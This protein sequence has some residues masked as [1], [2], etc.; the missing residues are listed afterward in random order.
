A[1]A[2]FAWL[3]SHAAAT[4]HAMR[5]T[6]IALAHLWGLWGLPAIACLLLFSISSGGWSGRIRPIDLHY[7]LAGLMPYSPAGGDFCDAFQQM[8]WDRWGVVGS[9]RPLAEAFR[10]LTVLVAQHSYVATLLVQLALLSIMLYLA[11]RSVVRWRGIWAGSAFVG[12]VLLLERPFLP[13]T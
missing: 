8:Y 3:G 11:A 13:T 2:T 7:N 10:Q 6:E 5:R 12:F 4:R 9:R 1:G